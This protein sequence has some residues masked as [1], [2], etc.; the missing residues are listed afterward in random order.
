LWETHN[1]LTNL[2]RR[3]KKK[4]IW[5]PKTTS[6]AAKAVTKATRLMPVDPWAE[7]GPSGISDVDGAAVADAVEDELLIGM[8]VACNVCCCSCCLSVVVPS[9]DT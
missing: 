1:I 5:M 8:D 7:P 4:P 3:S 2:F 9:Q 6:E